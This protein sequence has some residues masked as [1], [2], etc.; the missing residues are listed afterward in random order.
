VYTVSNFGTLF[1]LRLMIFTMC[2]LLPVVK[3]MEKWRPPA[4]D[5]A[6]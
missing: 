1:R 6:S 3:E 5:D 4:P 2:A